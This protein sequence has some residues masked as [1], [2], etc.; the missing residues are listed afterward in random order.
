MMSDRASEGD[1]QVLIQERKKWMLI[2]WSESRQ[3]ELTEE[4]FSLEQQRTL[5]NRVMTKSRD[6]LA[7]K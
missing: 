6:E 2:A 4:K 1:D 5:G 3:V 7:A